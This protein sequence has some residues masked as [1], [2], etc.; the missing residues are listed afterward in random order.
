M[1]AGEPYV[2]A[3]QLTMEDTTGAHFEQ[4][5]PVACL[6]PAAQHVSRALVREGLLKE[7]EVFRYVTSAYRVQSDPDTSEAAP[8]TA[9]ARWDC[10]AS[11]DSR[12]G[13]SPQNRG[14]SLDEVIDVEEVASALPLRES[15]LADT[16]TRATPF[17]PTDDVDLPVFIPRD[18]LD[19]TAELSRRAGSLE[20]GGILVGY[21][22]VDGSLGLSRRLGLSPSRVS[23]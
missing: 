3:L 18:V 2:G 13:D 19:E 7:G 9:M 4:A 8:A 23:R 11:R 21:L 17:V 20:T 1:I 15:R 16:L 14:Q 12:V 22:H 5:L 10:P 6:A